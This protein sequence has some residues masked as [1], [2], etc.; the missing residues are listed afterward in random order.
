MRLDKT[1]L[2]ARLRGWVTQAHDAGQRAECSVQLRLDMDG[3]LIVANPLDPL[4]RNV[5][6][7]VP[8]DTALAFDGSVMREIDATVADLAPQRETTE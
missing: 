5:S 1:E 6:R 3:L 7:L 2:A 4:A 8:W